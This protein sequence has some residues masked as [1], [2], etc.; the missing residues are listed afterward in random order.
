MEEVRE[1]FERFG[2]LKSF[3]DILAKRGMAFVSFFDLRAALMAKDRLQDAALSGRKID[4][5]YSL[6][7]D[8]DMKKPCDRTMNQVRATPA[9]RSGDTFSDDR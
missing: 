6:P 7:R 4:V 9:H 8:I 2:E 5:H 1:L 3:F